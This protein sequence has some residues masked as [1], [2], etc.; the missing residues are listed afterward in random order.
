[1]KPHFWRSGQTFPSTLAQ[2]HQLFASGEL[3]FTMSNNDSEVDNKV[4]QGVFPETSRAYVPESGT[5][6]NSHY[7]GIPKH[8]A[9]K[10]AA[11][12]AINFMMSPEAQYEKMKPAVWGDGTVLDRDRLPPRWQAQFASIPGRERA[13]D[14][15]E[16]APHA[17]RELA[18]E[19]M[20][21]LADD[22]RTRVI[23]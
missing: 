4:A 22:F 21:R 9:H 6:Q 5:I 23:E 19:Y 15:A 14:R 10:A 2:Q 13:P 8:A 7:L 12:V 11:L 16:I 17:L 20:L 3:A 18:P 1:M